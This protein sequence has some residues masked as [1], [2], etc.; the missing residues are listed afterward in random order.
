MHPSDTPE[1]LD[2]VPC[3]IPLVLD[4]DGTLLRTDSLIEAGALFMRTRPWAILP[5]L[6][7]LL[8][9][10]AFFKRALAGAVEL[11][12]ETLPINDAMADF[13]RRESERGRPVYLATATDEITA[14][15]IAARFPFIREVIGS[16]GVTNLKGEA[17]AERLVQRFPQGF[18]Y[19]GNDESDLKVWKKAKGVV[20]TQASPGLVR[21]ARVISSDAIVFKKP[22][23]IKA[24]VKALR[25]HQWAKNLLVFVP[26][27]LSGGLHDM[28]RLV[29]T[30]LAFL[31]L[32]LVASATY[33]L[34]DLWDLTND[35][36]HWS[37]K[38]RPLASGALPITHGIAVMLAGLAAGFLVALYVSL[39]LAGGIAVYLIGTVTYSLGLKKIP[40]LDVLTLAALF[41]LRL[42][43]GIVASQAPPSPWLLVFSMFVFS[44]L[45]YAKRH[46]EIA[47]MGEAQAEGVMGRGYLRSDLPL[48][49]ALGISSGVAAVL[50][51]I[52]YIINDAFTR[53]F[54][55]NVNWLWG[56]PAVLFVFVS[57]LWLVCLRGKL[58][59]DP[60]FFAVK[61]RISLALGGIFFI[62]F[63]MAWLGPSW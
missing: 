25:L 59:D 61:D 43:I 19:A 54:Y 3:E 63:M 1:N 12:C 39:P 46:T 42:G 4:L 28:P 44:S 45:C 31:A 32:G 33:I 41:T 17:K 35:R 40:I 2:K 52:L 47:R 13:A 16:D 57:R 6:G 36:R 9:G 23:V 10:K 26:L 29:D 49:M 56:F 7:G 38:N 24:F 62:C 30:V 60:V 21:R 50:I 27:A 14:R 11:D 15:K 55:G 20:V 34:N 48:V 58:S 37:K 53:S 22:P 51:M 5:L 18:I 8:K